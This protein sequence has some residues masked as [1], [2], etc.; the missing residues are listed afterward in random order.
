MYKDLYTSN[1]MNKI[2]YIISILF[3]ILSCNQYSKKISQSDFESL[4][5][6]D[7]IA[8]IA[9]SSSHEAKIKVRASE[10]SEKIY[11]LEIESPEIFTDSL[12][13]IRKRLSVQSIYPKYESVIYSSASSS[14]LIDVI[15]ILSV[16]IFLLFLWSAIDVLKNQF[17]NSVDKLIW[18]IVVLMPLFGPIFYL[19]IGRKQRLK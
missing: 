5:K 10:G 2:F 1:K 12:L 3:G 16:I 8:D 4:L 19:T 6:K 17:A 15:I 7:S 11:I 18:L 14:H 13:K 9:V